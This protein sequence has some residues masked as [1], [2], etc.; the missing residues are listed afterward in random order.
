MAVT[1]FDQ[2]TLEQVRAWRDAAIAD[3][4]DATPTYETE[5]IDRATRLRRDGWEAQVLTRDDSPQSISATVHLWGPDGLAVRTGIAYDFDK[6]KAGLRT[7]MACKAT[8]VDTQRYS[9]AGRCCAACRPE[10]ARRTE[11]PGWCD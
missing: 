5:S 1:R 7:C 2:L 3:G 9:F 8:D 4:W 6:L 10:M 11:Q